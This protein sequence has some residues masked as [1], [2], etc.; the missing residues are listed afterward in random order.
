MNPRYHVIA[1]P[2]RMAKKYAASR[3]WSDDEIIIVTRG[4]Q[5]AQLDPALIVSIVT[6]KLHQLGVRIIAEIREE[7]ERVRVLWPVPMMA[8]T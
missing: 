7:I 6:V 1:G 5:L 8:A 3:G 4:H 2:Y